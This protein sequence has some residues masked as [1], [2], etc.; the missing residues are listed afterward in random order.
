MNLEFSRWD[1]V[2][3]GAQI[4]ASLSLS[5]VP[6]SQ[7]LFTV[8]VNAGGEFGPSAFRGER[9]WLTISV[10]GIPLT[11]R[12]EVTPVP[13][14]QFAVNAPRDYALTAADGD[15]MD[16]VFLD[17]DGNVGIG[18]ASPSAPLHVAGP[19][20]IDGDASGARP[21]TGTSRSSP[22]TARRR[23]GCSHGCLRSSGT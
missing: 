23:C 19:I 22:V 6:V 21:A 8:E 18:I 1:A 20:K 17:N 14:A 5:D 4:G 12:Q 16:A 15:P 13:Y 9:R 7:G 10:N 11:P 3:D 2:V